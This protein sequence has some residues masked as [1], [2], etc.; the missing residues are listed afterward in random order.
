MHAFEP[1][2]NLSTGIFD[3]DVHTVAHRAASG[4]VGEMRAP[5]TTRLRREN[6]NILLIHLV[7]LHAI[8]DRSG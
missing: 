1:G 7:P 6:D 5:A 2:N 8:P 3:R 4:K